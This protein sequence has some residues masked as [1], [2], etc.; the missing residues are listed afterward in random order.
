[1]NSEPPGGKGTELGEDLCANRTGRTEATAGTL[2]VSPYP[3]VTCI[4][5][6]DYGTIFALEMVT[7]GSANRLNR[8]PYK[9]AQEV[10]R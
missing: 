2:H 10:I 6:C 9:T 3:E 8:T 4:P 7:S 1:M 5:A